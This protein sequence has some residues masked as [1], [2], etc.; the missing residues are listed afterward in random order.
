MIAIQKALA[1]IQES[2]IDIQR[3][4]INLDNRPFR[5]SSISLQ[6]GAAKL[7]EQGISLQEVANLIIP[8]IA[9]NDPVLQKYQGDVA[10]HSKQW[11]K[12]VSFYERALS[13]DSGFP[14]AHKALG[15]A[16]LNLGLYDSAIKSYE[17]ALKYTPVSPEAE[18]NLA[19][20]LL[21]RGA[22]DRAHGILQHLLF[23]TRG[24]PSRAERNFQ[25]HNEVVSGQYFASRFKL[26]DRIGQLHYLIDK[27]LIDRSFN[28]LI[29]RYRS[30][31]VELESDSAR[32]PYAPL[33]QKDLAGFAGYFDKLLFYDEPTRLATSILNDSIDYDELGKRYSKKRLVYIDDLLTPEALA[34]LRRFLLRSTIFFRHSEAGFVGSYLMDGFSSS[35]VLNIAAELQRRLPTVLKNRPLNNA[36]CYRYQ[37]IGSGVKLHNGD[38]S[39]TLNLWLTPDSAN[40]TPGGGGMTIYDK[41]HPIE[42]DW[43]YFNMNKDRQDVEEQIKTLI[44]DADSV[45]IPYK[46]NRAVL[47]HS[48]LFHKTD[49]FRF[50]DRF[51]DRRMNMTMLFGRRG[52]DASKLK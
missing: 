51:V 5:D 39:V 20:A 31:L 14:E 40:L 34:S 35:L 17:Y 21:S 12:A 50:A 43:L 38:G 47:F 3:T 29:E 18:N 37:S 11:D 28:R 42:W 25:E 4:T 26:V 8:D 33:S 22:Y 19:I 23:L 27:E 1:Q 9:S 52:Q 32:M 44:S 13:L 36:W 49:P 46:F 15:D 24:L 6:Q 7:L 48:T 41:E 10:S 2:A 16:C 30:L 45:T